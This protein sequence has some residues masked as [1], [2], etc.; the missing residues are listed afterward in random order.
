MSSGKLMKA[1][2]WAKR[3]FED[4]SIPD[5]RTIKRWVETGMLKG[6]IVDC[7]VWVNSQERW[8][9]ESIISSCVSDL[10]RAS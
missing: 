10:I 3:E 2:A 6:K 1:S 7:S 4:G 5:N 9:V 8:G